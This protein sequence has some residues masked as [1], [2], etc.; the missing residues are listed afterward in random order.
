MAWRSL[1]STTS[2][3][4]TLALTLVFGGSAAAQEREPGQPVTAT[5]ICLIAEAAATAN[6]LP[7]EFFARLIWQESRFRPE[8]VGPMTRSGERARGI[9][10]FM[11]RTAS[12]RGLLDPNDPVQALPKSAEF[13]RQLIHEF[14]NLGLAAAAYNA[15]PQRVRDWLE[16]RGSLP[17]ETQRYVEI[18]TGHPAAEWAKATTSLPEQHS[19][20]MSCDSMMALL[21]EQPNLYLTRL[22]QHVDK[23]VAS[24]WGVQV[25]AGFSRA[26]ALASYSDIEKRNRGSLS[27]LDPIIMQTMLRSRG[28]QPFY[29]VRIGADTRADAD[30][31]CA[32]LRKGGTACIVLRNRA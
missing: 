24:P 12:E 6:G 23:S 5:S 7:F 25:S 11:P 31:L 15:G 8:A 26:R 10:Q 2:A 3:V 21:R 14:G 29:Q 13:L 32:S 30:R 22:Q 16:G 1:I 4:L 18:I 17:A 9:A 27:G 20:P 28:T 19:K